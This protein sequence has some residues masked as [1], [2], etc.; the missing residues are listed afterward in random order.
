[1]VKLAPKRAELKEESTIRAANFL[2]VTHPKIQAADLYSR[3]RQEGILVRYFD[4]PRI[5]NYL[6]ITVGTPV[7]VQRLVEALGAV[8]VK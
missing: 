4:L 3:L 2:F 7:E 1:M 8:L 6:R 5:D